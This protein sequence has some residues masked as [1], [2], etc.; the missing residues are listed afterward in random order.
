[1]TLQALLV[2][3]DDDAADVLG[4]VLAGFGLAV[5]RFSEPEIALQRLAEQRFEC[6]IVDCD[7]ADTAR[8]LLE[9]VPNGKPGVIIPMALLSQESD[10]RKVLSGGAKFILRKPL[11][12][13]HAAAT[14]RAVT[15]LLRRERRRSFRVP[16]QAAVQISLAG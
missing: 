5:E 14:L 1:M 8:N 13:D 15:A 3:K 6:L 9:T 11:S 16:V 4:R 12:D 2:S 7:E 10:V